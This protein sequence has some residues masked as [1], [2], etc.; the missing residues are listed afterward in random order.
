MQLVKNFWWFSSLI[1]NSLSHIFLKLEFKLG[2]QLLMK[3]EKKSKG[4]NGMKLVN[5][6]KT[7]C[8]LLVD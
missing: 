2:G 5:E 4:S 1:I 6:E 7:S 3:S 8:A